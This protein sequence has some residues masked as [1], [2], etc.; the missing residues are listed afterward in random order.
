MALPA[1][2]GGGLAWAGLD[3]AATPEPG[4]VPPPQQLPAPQAPLRFDPQRLGEVKP[5][6]RFDQS[7]DELVRQGVVTPDERTFLRGGAGAPLD[8]GAFQQACRNGALSAR[9]CRGGIALRWGRRLQI[10][11]AHV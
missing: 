3:P 9:E 1:L 2:L 8:V 11:R 6:K 10:G 4:P 5:P 7:L